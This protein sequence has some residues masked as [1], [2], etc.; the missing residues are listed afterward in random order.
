MV[1]TLLFLTNE[2]TNSEHKHIYKVPVHLCA[3]FYVHG[4]GPLTQ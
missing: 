3:C 2:E 1:W 4:V